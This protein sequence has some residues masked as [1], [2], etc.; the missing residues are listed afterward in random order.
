[1][2]IGTILVE[3]AKNAGVELGE[4]GLM[5]FYGVLEKTAARAVADSE[6]TATEKTIAGGLAA[7]LTTFKESAK[8]AADLNKDGKIG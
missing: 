2:R 7:I 3:E 5:K 8:Q 4:E 1:M 6:T